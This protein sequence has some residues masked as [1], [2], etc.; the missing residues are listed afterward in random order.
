MVFLSTFRIMKLLIMFSTIG[1][2]ILGFFCVG[3]FHKTSMKM[4]GMDPSAM[5][6][7][8]GEQTCCGGSMS[9]HIQSWTN[10]FLTIPQDLRNNFTLLA[11]GLLL[12][13]VFVRSLFSYTATDQRLLVDNLHLRQRPSLLAF[14]PLKLAFARG[15]LNPKLY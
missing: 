9:Q 4:D 10:T 8:K 15:I 2:L 13:L 12:A 7:I 5:V 14:N 3:M 6:S 1:A 11:L